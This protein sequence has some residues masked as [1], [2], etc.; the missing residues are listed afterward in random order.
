MEETLENTEMAHQRL[1][2]TFNQLTSG[3]SLT[4]KISA[5]LF[6]FFVFWVVFLV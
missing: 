2:R 1:M 3:R 5:I 4:Y 6:L